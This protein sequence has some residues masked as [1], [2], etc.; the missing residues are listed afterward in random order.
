MDIKNYSEEQLEY[1]FSDDFKKEK[2]RALRTAYKTMFSREYEKYQDELFNEI[3]GFEFI[4][5]RTEIIER[6]LLIIKKTE[7]F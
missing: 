3:K 6:L 1:Y 4:D 7:S 5:L 2:V